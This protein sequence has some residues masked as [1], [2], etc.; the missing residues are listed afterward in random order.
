M[1]ALTSAQ[2]QAVLLETVN[3]V[4]PKMFESGDSTMMLFSGGKKLSTTTRSF[5]Q[6][7]MMYPGGNYRYVDFEGDYG[8]GSA[9]QPVLATSVPSSA[10]SRPNS[11]PASRCSPTPTRSRC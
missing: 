5:R 8:R 10:S 1:S 3:T 6:P 9:Y 11:P 7:L 4:V 2:I